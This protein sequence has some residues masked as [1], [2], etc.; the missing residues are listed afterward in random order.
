[1]IA[2][3]PFGQTALTPIARTLRTPKGILLLVFAPVLILAAGAAGPANV[4]PNLLAAISVAAALD[5]A[6]TRLRRGVW[7]IPDGAILTGLIIAL[8]LRPQEPVAVAG[9]TSGIAIAGKHLLRTRWSNVFNPAALALV[10]S[11]FLF[12]AGQSWW[13][14][15]PESGLVGVVVLVACGLFIADRINKLPL[16]AVFLGAYFFLFTEAS[17]LI[18]P[19]NVAEIFRSPDLQAALF[20]AFFMLDDPPTCPVRYRDQVGFA[21]ITAVAS[22]AVF[23]ATGSVYFLL[24][25]LLV[26][27]ACESIRRSLPSA[28]LRLLA[29]DRA[30]FAR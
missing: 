13:G 21:L 3:L 19:A 17:F 27:N 16:V 4:L 24:A 9:A 26:A 2:A 6:A 15:L 1:V 18:N 12:G 23:L 29:G 5:L 25:G 11:Y 8:V 20:F 28:W 30:R 14:A 22:Y 7:I 10:A